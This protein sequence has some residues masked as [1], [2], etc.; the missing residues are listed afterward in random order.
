MEKW[1]S[2]KDDATLK[3]LDLSANILA[4]LAQL[5][6]VFTYGFFS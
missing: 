1:N 4:L 3:Q 5:N 2:C 6:S